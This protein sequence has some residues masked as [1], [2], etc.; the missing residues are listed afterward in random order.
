MGQYNVQ[1]QTSQAIPSKYTW[2]IRIST[3][4]K[5]IGNQQKHFLCLMS[6]K[7]NEHHRPHNLKI[8]FLG[9]F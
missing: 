8:K 1:K 4:E 3:A 5:P 6:I 9:H 7:C 2:D